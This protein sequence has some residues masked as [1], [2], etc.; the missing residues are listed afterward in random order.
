MSFPPI[1]EVSTGTNVGL[2]A[3][4]LVK[5]RGVTVW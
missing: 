4:V 2:E 1:N 3:H 5:V